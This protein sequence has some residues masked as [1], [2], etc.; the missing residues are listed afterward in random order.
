[1]NESR[2]SRYARQ[3]FPPC[4]TYLIFVSV[5]RL[6]NWNFFAARDSPIT[7]SKRGVL[8]FGLMIICG[9]ENLNPTDYIGY[10][11]YCGLGGSGTPVDDTDR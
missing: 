5:Q 1:M 9:V 11:C 7:T 6:L 2:N 8:E 3:I 10:G 4:I